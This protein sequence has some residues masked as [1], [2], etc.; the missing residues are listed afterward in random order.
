MGSIFNFF[1]F[2]LLWSV[3][4][5]FHRVFVP[6]FCLFPSRCYP[7]SCWE[8]AKAKEKYGFLIKFIKIKTRKAHL[9]FTVQSLVGKVW[10]KFLQIFVSRIAKFLN[11]WTPRKISFPAQFTY[12]ISIVLSPVC[13][14][15][16]FE[17]AH[18]F[19]RE[20]FP[21]DVTINIFGPEIRWIFFEI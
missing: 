7:C 8:M 18:K 5:H 6:S 11:K 13:S 2:R 10:K 1:I 17:Q 9:N 16:L 21:S 20:S 3:Q 19:S 15:K 14:H 12:K 4:K